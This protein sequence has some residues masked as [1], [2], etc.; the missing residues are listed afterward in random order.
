MATNVKTRG[1]RRLHLE[2]IHYFLYYRLR[3]TA[4]QI[5]ALRHTSRGS[6]PGL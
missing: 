1:V 2:R 3:G 5:L 6:G 4:V